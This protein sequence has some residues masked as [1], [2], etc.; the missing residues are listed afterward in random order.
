MMG[1]QLNLLG[2]SVRDVLDPT[3]RGEGQEALSFM[4]PSVYYKPG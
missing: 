2:D 3:L 1:L 4:T